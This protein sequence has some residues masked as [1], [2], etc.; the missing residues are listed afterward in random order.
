VGKTVLIM[1]L[2]HNI[3][4]HLRGVSVFCGI[5]ERCREGDKLSREIRAAGS[6][7]SAKSYLSWIDSI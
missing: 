7:Q 1:E 6:L 4:G 3:I 2:I 5:G